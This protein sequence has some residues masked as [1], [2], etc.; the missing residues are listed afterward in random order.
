M[1]TSV[2]SGQTVARV[3]WRAPIRLKAFVIVPSVSFMEFSMLADLIN[4]IV[5]SH[6]CM[7]II[8]DRKV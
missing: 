7:H 4:T 6:K 8:A 5:K 1:Y 2:L 3:G